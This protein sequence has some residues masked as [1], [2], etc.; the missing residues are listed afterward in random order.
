MRP[1]VISL[2]LETRP[3]EE[4]GELIAAVERLGQRSA[5]KHVDRKVK[6]RGLG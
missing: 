5:L 4:P 3:P 6:V 2:F 1:D